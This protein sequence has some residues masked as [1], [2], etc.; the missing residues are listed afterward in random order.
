[1]KKPTRLFRLASSLLCVLLIA[2]LT[3]PGASAAGRTVR[4]GIFSLGQFQG[5]NENGEAQGYNI[6]YL[7]R[8]GQSTHWNYEYVEV[9]NWVEATE[10][11][12]KDEIDLLAPAQKTDA[13]TAAFDYSVYSMGTEFAAVYTLA[14]RQDLL[15]E[16]F[17][18]M[19][20]LKYGGAKNST[21][22][23]KFLEEYSVDAGFTPD[24]TLYNNTTELFD[25]LR[26]GEVDAIV[27]NI[28]FA[29]DD[30]MLLGR[31]HPMPV[32]YITSKGNTSL[33]DELNDAMIDVRMADPAFETEL[34][35]R[36]FPMYNN[37]QFTYDETQFIA[38]MPV[39]AIGYQVNQAPLSY[40]DPNTGE[41]AGITR[42]ILD[43]ISR[44]SG[45]TFQYIAL[46]ATDV[47]YAYLQEHQIH[48]LSNVEYNDINASQSTMQLSTP[49][50]ES[51]KVLV[52]RQNLTLN[53]DSS[54]HVALSTG[55]ATLTKVIA[56][57]YPY[58]Q[59]EVYATAEECFNAVKNG[60][61]DATMQNRQVA[62]VQLTNPAYSDLSVLPI[63][64]LTDKLCLS[65][66]SYPSD[67][68]EY[69][70]R[71]NSGIFI[72]IM[73]KAIKQMSTLA[74]DSIIIKDTVACRYQTTFFDFLYTYRVSLSCVTLLVAVC[75]LLLGRSRRIEMAKNQELGL[76]NS[77][78]A[79]AVNQAQ[80]ANTAKSQFL[81]RMSHEIRTPMNAIVGITA[82]AKTHLR[83]EARM[84]E[85]LEKIDSSS[86]I[87]LNI[88]NDV[89]DMS[90]IESD[91]LKIAHVPFELKALLQGI[92][93]MYYAQ[94]KQKGI[95]FDLLLEDVTEEFLIGDSLRVNQ[96]LLNLLSNA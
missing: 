25:A 92:S 75:L 66:I 53:A 54:L 6:D 52:S 49:Y 18:A 8:I 14:D 96:I 32:Y 12:E 56:E 51:A 45:L 24:L 43:K 21:F 60:T 36:Y 3:V 34:M 50:L 88:I 40:T 83:E 70:Q 15:Y 64:S 80:R 89:L 79:D 13:L 10:L 42:D 39:I 87:L 62:E 37:T 84:N 65:T 7:N 30:V 4:V 63:Q 82:I 58:F 72:S 5:F 22:T 81:S 86:K 28:M 85:Y 2:A 73:D 31:F 17:N 93:S 76:K 44:K 55:S 41:F 1:M 94:C 11:L 67:T 91:K 47:T 78:L 59:I 29:G 95:Q 57:A 46:P 38:A 48:V 71:L 33:L 61:C 27:T 16:D 35:S 74:V 20:K 19:A 23:T 26:S 90:A 68:S 77:Q 9:A 69:A